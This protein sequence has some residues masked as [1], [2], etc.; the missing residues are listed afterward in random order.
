MVDMQTFNILTLSDIE[1]LKRQPLNGN[2]TFDL[3]NTEQDICRA[4]LETL[5]PDCRVQASFTGKI[6]LLFQLYEKAIKERKER[7]NE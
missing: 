6:A 3:S 2:C 4:H 7:K 1:W 5:Y